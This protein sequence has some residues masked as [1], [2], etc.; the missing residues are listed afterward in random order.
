VC[1]VWG[2]E[3]LKIQPTPI[4]FPST[5]PSCELVHRNLQNASKF[6]RLLYPLSHLGGRHFTPLRVPGR[7]AFGRKPDGL[8]VSSVAWRS[9]AA[10][11]PDPKIP[12]IAA[13]TNQP[14]R[15]CTPAAR[16]S[17]RLSGRCRME[18]ENVQ[19]FRASGNPQPQRAAPAY[20]RDS[21][22]RKGQKWE[23]R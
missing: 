7:R 2:A 15:T 23:R 17:S 3:L 8:R 22:A 1:V 14:G 19:G 5:P 12:C 20:H 18:R 21:W 4:R 13:T 9:P 16:P 10:R 11:V 6:Y